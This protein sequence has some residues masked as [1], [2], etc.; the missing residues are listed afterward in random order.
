MEAFYTSFKQSLLRQQTSQ[1]L[2]PIG[3]K[4]S[5]RLKF[6]SNEHTTVCQKT[7]RNLIS[8]SISF[9]FPELCE[10]MSY[11]ET[12]VCLKLPFWN[13]SWSPKIKSTIELK[14]L[15]RK[16]INLLDFLKKLLQGRAIYIKAWCCKC[17]EY[18][19]WLCHINSILIWLIRWCW[20]K[21]SAMTI[22]VKTFNCN[23]FD[24]P[25]LIA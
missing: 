22:A 9:F 8:L 16:S 7:G 13:I 11:P 4:K 17:Q 12:K 5:R 2:M 20:E 23:C 1:K 18:S 19:E 15:I 6:P 3:W 21:K 24:I 14:L 25:K 10:S